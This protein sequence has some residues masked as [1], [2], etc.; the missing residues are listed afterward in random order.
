MRCLCGKIVKVI[1]QREIFCNTSISL[2][3]CKCGNFLEERGGSSFDLN[4]EWSWHGN[5][6]QLYKKDFTR[7]LKFLGKK[8]INGYNYPQFIAIETK[9]IILTED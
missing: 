8:E 3:K 1:K 9:H 4:G 7:L 6:S 5:I 2:G